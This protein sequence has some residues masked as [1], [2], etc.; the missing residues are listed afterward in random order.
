MGAAMNESCR[1]WVRTGRC[2]TRLLWGGEILP[3][4][5][6]F[7]VCQARLICIKSQ[8]HAQSCMRILDSRGNARYSVACLIAAD[9]C[10]ATAERARPP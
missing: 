8:R 4:R 2:D 5:E 6:R 7:Q 3:F 1:V 9:F 10:P